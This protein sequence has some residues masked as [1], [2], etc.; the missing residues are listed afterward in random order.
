M[1]IDWGQ[2][3]KGWQ[4]GIGAFLG[5]GAIIVGALFNAHLNRKRDT[6]L[7]SDEM[8]AVASA[9]YGEIVIVR[10]AVARMANAVAHRFVEHGVGNIRDEPFDRHFIEQ[11]TLPPLRLY[12]SLAAKVG[13]L[14][15]QIALEIVRFYA[16]VEE[17]Q[18]WL[19][20]LREDA[21]R[22]F[23]YSVCYVLDPAIDAITGVLPALTA[24]ED[25]A[26]IEERIGTP[27]IKKAIDAQDFERMRNEP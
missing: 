16:R 9:L 25:L 2:E 7:R 1:S 6:R 12:P 5:F 15:S 26:G 14:P 10:Q 17:A 20:R 27:D 13:M 19:P 22:P 21:E 23:T 18:A 3:L 11:I 24:I 4:T 8:I